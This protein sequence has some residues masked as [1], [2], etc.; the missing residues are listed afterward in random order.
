MHFFNCENS[1][2]GE[3]WFWSQM[4]RI[5][6]P[7]IDLQFSFN[8]KENWVPLMNTKQGETQVQ[9]LGL[10]KIEF[11]AINWNEPSWTVLSVQFRV[12]F[13]GSSASSDSWPR[14]DPIT[15][16]DRSMTN[17]LCKKF[18]SNFRFPLM[19]MN[20]VLDFN[21]LNRHSLCRVKFSS[22]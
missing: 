5:I 19:K 4:S 2:S 21:Q 6:A 7:L 14:V 10:A 8:L 13:A 15:I 18:G 9:I 3:M 1:L 12:N 22:D 11:I 16:I 17:L 20:Q